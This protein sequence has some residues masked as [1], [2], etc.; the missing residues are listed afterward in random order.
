MPVEFDIRKREAEI[1]GKPQRI[2]PIKKSDLDP[3]DVKVIED[4]RETLVGVL[5]NEESDIF[6]VM[7]RHPG[8]FKCQMEAALQLIKKG[9]IPRREQELIILRVAWLSRAPYEWGE[10]VRLALGQGVST[11]EIQR[12]RKSSAEQG[13]SDHDRAIICGVDELLEHKMLSDEIWDVLA[14]S[15][16]EKQLM[17]FPYLVGQ[18][19]STALVQNS[20]RI[21]LDKYNRGLGQVD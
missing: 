4:V 1:L 21:R 11:D 6:G 19:F 12:V 20:L 17:E 13:W 15:W 16:N 9:T 18:Y 14:L 3:A 5:T 2:T 10:H 7:C 8:V